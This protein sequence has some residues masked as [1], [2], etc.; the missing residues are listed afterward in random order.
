[1]RYEPGRS[2]AARWALAATIS[3]RPLVS[4]SASKVPLEIP[5]RHREDRACPAVHVPRST[6]NC[7]NCKTLDDRSQRQTLDIIFER[8]ASGSDSRCCGADQTDPF[9]DEI[10]RG[11]RF[12][13]VFYLIVREGSYTAAARVSM[14]TICST[15]KPMTRILAPRRTVQ[16]LVRAVGRHEIGNIADDEKFAGSCVE[17]DLRRYARIT[18]SDQ[19]DTGILSRSAKW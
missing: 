5:N 11:K 3:K 15:S 17:D 12:M 10:A 8:R 14:S 7:A 1:M 2:R 4:S 13:T 9:P 6:E 16:I 18:A 19:H